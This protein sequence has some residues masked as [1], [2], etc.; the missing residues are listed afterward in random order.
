[1][2]FSFFSALVLSVVTVLSIGYQAKAFRTSPKLVSQIA[3]QTSEKT[4]GG[5]FLVVANNGVVFETD[6]LYS[7]KAHL[8]RQKTGSRCIFEVKGGVVI[9]NPRKI[10]KHRQ[11]ARNGFN[12]SWTDRKDIRRMEEIANN[13]SNREKVPFSE[14]DQ[15][16]REPVTVPEMELTPTESDGLPVEVPERN[17]NVNTQGTN[18]V[19]G[20]FLVVASDRVYR[21][22]TY[23]SSA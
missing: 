6:D 23:I 12:K 5:L 20:L 21:K 16:S 2:A 11:N 15:D 17:G 18:N 22:V 9:S 7:A 4:A 3:L 13:Y 10:A 8:G 1:M 14:T 19:L